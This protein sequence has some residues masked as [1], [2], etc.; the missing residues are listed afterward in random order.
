[1]AW[2]AHLILFLLVIAENALS[3][4]LTALTVVQV[5][6]TGKTNERVDMADT[7]KTVRLNTRSK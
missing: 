4:L 3:L 5:H 1:M 2:Q 7:V 6:F